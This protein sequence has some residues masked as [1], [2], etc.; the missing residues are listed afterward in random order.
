MYDFAYH[1]PTHLAQAAELLQSDAEAR[2]LAGGMSLLPS[3]KLRLARTPALID[4]GAIAPLAGIRHDA[5]M[6][7]LGAMTTHAAVASSAL[8]QSLVPGLARLAAGIGDPMVRNRGTVGGSVANADPAADYPAAV[9]ALDALIV[10]Q[11]REIAAQAFFTGLYETALAPDEIITEVRFPVPR[12]AGYAKL[13]HPASRFAVMGVMVARSASDEVRVAVTGAGP[14]VFRVEA[15]EAALSRRFDP[16][17]LDEVSLDPVQLMADIHGSAEYRAL[18]F[19]P[20]AKKA[21][22]DAVRSGGERGQG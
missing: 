2:L 19:R 7:A 6:L 15:A 4:L 13:R 11:R 22:A 5:A 12:C 20:L 9:L 10:T 21:L 1:Q 3:L 18:C 14:R 16:A 17:A 8:V